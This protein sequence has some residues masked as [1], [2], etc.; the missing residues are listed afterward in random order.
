MA[1]SNDCYNGD[2]YYSD[3]TGKH[4]ETSDLTIF[5]SQY[6]IGRRIVK[7]VK[8]ALVS[9]LSDNQKPDGKREFQDINMLFLGPTYKS[10]RNQTRKD[11]GNFLNARVELSFEKI[12]LICN[13]CVLNSSSLPKNY[14]DI[15]FIQVLQQRPQDVLHIL[16]FDEAHWG[17]NSGSVIDNFFQYLVQVCENI[18]ETNGSMPSL[19]I[20][21]VSATIDVLSRV[22]DSY[23]DDGHHVDWSELRRSDSAKFG[24][25]DY[26]DISNLRLRNDPNPTILRQRT[27]VERSAIVRDEYR[28]TIKACLTHFITQRNTDCQNDDWQDNATWTAVKFLF[29][30]NTIDEISARACSTD[31]N[32]TDNYMILLRLQSNEHIDEL[33]KATIEM[34]HR[35]TKKRTSEFQPFEVIRLVQ[36]SDS[37]SK[38]LSPKAHRHLRRNHQAVDDTLDVSQLFNL[39]CLILVNDKLGMGERLSPNCM[40]FDVRSRY[41]GDAGDM[42]GFASTFIQDIGR[43]CGHKKP[44][45]LVLMS[46]T[47]NDDQASGETG[48]LMLEDVSFVQLHRLLTRNQKAAGSHPERHAKVFTKLSPYSIILDAEPQIG[49]TGAILSM[50]DILYSE[51][52][53]RSKISPY[54]SRT[55]VCQPITTAPQLMTTAPRLITPRFS[56][57]QSITAR[58]CRI[59]TKSDEAVDTRIQQLKRVLSNDNLFQQYHDMIGQFKEA[60]ELS[61]SIYNN[62]LIAPMNSARKAKQEVFS[63]V[64]CGCG[65]HGIL[66]I[67]IANSSDLDLPVRII[68]IDLHESILQLKT[69]ETTPN[70]TFIGHVGDMASTDETVINNSPF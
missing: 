20:L 13:N 64:D 24:T 53:S 47:D 41:K 27:M 50:L 14:E 17:I 34:F 36:D 21:L 25:P 2:G 43:C 16:V 11:L 22:I 54:A 46:I 15:H 49:K 31:Y 33:H 57:L 26:R 23:K 59:A 38:Q 28:K 37:I 63:L 62:N 29:P 3:G 4:L 68:G 48:Q 66:H 67:F 1:T 40:A 70:V 10:L 6:N 18:I 65:L 69:S 19:F 45:A 60:K 39:P 61:E 12:Q 32:A 7:T 44:E 42:K 9:I 55:T 5:R 52:T 30:G 51:H 35:V 58:L 56:K 8:D